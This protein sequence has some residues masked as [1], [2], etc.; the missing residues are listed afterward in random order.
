MHKRL[1][2]IIFQ[3]TAKLASLTGGVTEARIA[4]ALLLGISTYFSSGKK[5][6]VVTEKD[7][8]KA[9]NLA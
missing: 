9:E 7:D 8:K 3:K 6:K 2:R 5:Q 1:A 4:S